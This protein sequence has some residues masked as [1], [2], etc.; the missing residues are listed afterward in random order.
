MKPRHLVMCAFGTYAD[1]CELPF[2]EF[3][4]SGLFLVTGSTG[5]GK[6]TIF[7]AISFALFGEASGSNRTNDTLRSDYADVQTKTYVELTFEHRGQEY[8]IYRQ[9]SYLRP[10]LTGEGETRVNGSATLTLPD[11]TVIDKEKNVTAYITELLGFNHGQFKQIAMIAQGEFLQLLLAD[12]K[13]RAVIFRRLF[14]TDFY[15]RIQELLK[16]QEKELR[17][18]CQ[19]LKRSELQSMAAIIIDLDN[20]TA[21]ELTALIAQNSEHVAEQ[22]LQLLIAQNESDAKADEALCGQN[23]QLAKLV[24][25]LTRQITEA[26]FINDRFAELELA[27]AA[28]V[29]LAARE[30]AMKELAQK[31]SRAELA[32]AKVQP[33]AKDWQR[34]QAALVQAEARITELTHEVEQRRPAVAS[35]L[36]AF[37]QEQ[38]REPE[39]EQVAAEVR[40][41]TESLPKYESLDKLSHGLE[42][43][44]QQQQE[45]VDQRS[46]LQEEKLIL[47]QKSTELTT[48]LQDLTEVDQQLTRVENQIGQIDQRLNTLL[49]LT[50][51]LAEIRR[52]ISE[53]NKAQEYYRQQLQHYKNAQQ[54]MRQQEALFYDEQAGLLAEKLLP[55]EPCPVC[56]S[57][58]HPNKAV[59]TLQPPSQEKLL[60]TGEYC[61]K[62]QSEVQKA[63]NLA[64]ELQTR[65]TTGLHNIREQTAAVLETDSLP[66]SIQAG[67]LQTALQEAQT[68]FETSRQQA[69]VEHDKLK[70][71]SQRRIQAMAELTAASEQKAADDTLLEE[72]NTKLNTLAVSIGAAESSIQSLSSD[73]ACPT[74]EAAKAELQSAQQRLQELKVVLQT[75][76]ENYEKGQSALNEQQ[77]LLLAEEERLPA[78]KKRAAEAREAFT[79]AMAALG[80]ASEADYQQALITEP[81]LKAGRQSLSEYE[82]ER[83]RIADQIDRLA[84][85]TRERKFVDISSLKEKL[86]EAEDL[87]NEQEKLEKIIFARLDNN[88]RVAAGLQ[89]SENERWHYQEKLSLIS[90]LAKTANGELNSKQKIAFEQ[91]VQAAYFDQ[92][93][94]EANK[95][96]ALMTDNR[97]T[98]LRQE[99]AKDLRSQSGLDLEVMDQ[100]TG[101][102]RAVRSLSGGESFKASLALALGLSDIVQQ[103]AGGAAID[104]LFIDEGFGALDNESLEQAI[105]ILSSLATG[106][107]LVGI[108]S[109]VAEL[110]E[111]IEHKLVVYGSTSGSHI[112][113]VKP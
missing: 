97:Y 57:L 31:I 76:Q 21:T 40:A 59:V 81:E 91:Y 98:L 30:D 29:A 45:L 10:R 71:L 28:S 27:K 80:F 22:V 100:Y 25:D 87:K 20:S 39:R 5:A 43:L 111:R 113:M 50:G 105:N 69:T 6:T 14:G 34:E 77:T 49:R 96:L 11:K 13:D 4:E 102:R 32:E 61:D 26:K 65:V 64:G 68:R 78:V 38:E 63:S 108:I 95:R 19:E 52:Q 104:T 56:G 53:K 74:L 82:K 1:R 112:K 36:Q 37:Q 66:E 41:F 109:H 15:Q 16:L 35:W 92:V 54:E 107:R 9:P 79:A 7:D 73:L 60:E 2:S 62:L 24:S 55:G 86:K 8:S 88:Q 93:L 42:S 17:E 90:G 101:V 85:A 84:E 44:K 94:V 83:Q 110:K 99:T 103:S 51:N 48:E 47:T 23:A 3:L 70:A 67:E 89:H 75:A 106:D 58:E 12:S 33:L 18:I 46:Q 72:I